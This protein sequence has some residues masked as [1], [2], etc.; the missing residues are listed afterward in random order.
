MT[1]DQPGCRL[2]NL[3]GDQ[4]PLISPSLFASF[5][6][7][8]GHELLTIVDDARRSICFH[9]R[10]TFTDSFSLSLTRRLSFSLALVSS[11]GANTVLHCLLYFNLLKERYLNVFIWLVLFFF[12]SLLFPLV[13]ARRSRDAS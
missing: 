7:I 11:S 4:L 6:A 9:W 1:S 13:I 5:E 12:Y 2:A 8:A 10:P 3:L